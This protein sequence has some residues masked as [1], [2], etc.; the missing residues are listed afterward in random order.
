MVL[1]CLQKFPNL[2]ELCAKCLVRMSIPGT[3]GQISKA[4]EEREI[5][6]QFCFLLEA[7]V[8]AEDGQQ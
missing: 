4:R 2:T 6:M 1:E 7:S 3:M 8:V 5:R